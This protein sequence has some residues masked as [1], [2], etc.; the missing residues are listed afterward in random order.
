M[1]IKLKS[2]NVF[3]SFRFEIV[4]YSIL[5]LFYTIVTE[6]IIYCLLF[7]I[8]SFI[9]GIV[10]NNGGS[11]NNLWNSNLI[12]PIQNGTS[13]VD[14]NSST[15]ITYSLSNVLTINRDYLII[16]I[17]LAFAV[18]TILFILYFLL[19]TKR[20][21]NYLYEIKDGIQT[22]A[23]GDFTTRI[24]VKNEDEF[25]VIA[26]SINKMANDINEMM[27]NERKDEQVKHELITSVAHDLRTPLTSII[28]Y[29]ELANR[30]GIDEENRKK[31]LG[32]AYSKSKRLERLIEDLFSF[33]K[34]SS[35][36]VQVEKHK[37][38]LVKL[39]EQMVEEFYPSFEDANLKHSFHTNTNEGYVNGDGNLLARA[40]G[41]LI[42]NAVKYGKDGKLV[43]IK[44]E[45]QG[46]NM[47]VAIQNYGTII[48]EKELPYIFDK[49]FRVEAS[50]SADTGGSGLGLAI[51]KKIILLHDGTITVKSDYNGT[52]FEVTLPKY[53]T[54]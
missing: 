44:V 25:A 38:N 15:G 21:S 54:S 49:F 34:F 31:Y 35:G 11:L 9:N 14:G 30:P 47:V 19:L 53:E 24:R 29:L 48:P 23:S 39:V 10:G 27:T 1:D 37:L 43:R 2:E 26:S 6:A 20:F 50:R 42:S 5:S 17:I 41:N 33:T 4:L 46:Q 32:I 36:E 16:T 7:Y 51:C 22:I 28:G 13:F 52:V 40:I 12:V 18:G 8:K 3:K 45:E